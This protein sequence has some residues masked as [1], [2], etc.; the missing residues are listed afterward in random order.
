M[1]RA[2]TELFPITPKNWGQI[3][4]DLKRTDLC[5]TLQDRPVP[6]EPEH[7]KFYI[8]LPRNYTFRGS[9]KN[10]TSPYTVLELYLLVHKSIFNHVETWPWKPS[11]SWAS[12]FA[13]AQ[14][15]GNEV[16][17]SGS[18]CGTQTVSNRASEIV[19]ITFSQSCNTC[20]RQGR[21]VGIWSCSVI[22]I[23]NGTIFSPLVIQ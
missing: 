9:N 15:P 19:D 2:V 6:I 22:R 17:K 10:S 23:R 7:Q 14:Y 5:K 12:E 4:A 8:L 3:C 1:Y 20:T 11:A 21:A 16:L 18:D 13:P